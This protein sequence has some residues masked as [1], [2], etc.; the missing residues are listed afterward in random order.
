MR[1]CIGVL[2]ERLRPPRPA[3]AGRREYLPPMTEIRPP[4]RRTLR[5][6]PVTAHPNPLLQRQSARDLRRWGAG[7]R[8]DSD[9][10]AG[11]HSGPRASHS[12]ADALGVAPSSPSLA[13]L[14]SSATPLPDG[15]KRRPPSAS[16]CRSSWPL[17]CGFSFVLVFSCL[18]SPSPASPFPRLSYAY[19]RFHAHS[20][21]PI[22]MLVR[23][24]FTDRF[25]RTR[26]CPIQFTSTSIHIYPAPPSSESPFPAPPSRVPAL[27]PLSSD[28]LPLSL[29]PLSSGVRSLYLLIFLSLRSPH[30]RPQSQSGSIFSVFWYPGVHGPYAHALFAFPLL[31]SRSP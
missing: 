8:E 19:K 18:F 20:S 24:L 16:S 15:A 29:L 7:V 22:P 3:P 28:V 17:T 1:I 26:H 25:L 14:D 27:L 31:P 4:C 10:V 2:R 12:T 6:H 9:G 5:L 23:F 13:W 11:T 30:A 21:L